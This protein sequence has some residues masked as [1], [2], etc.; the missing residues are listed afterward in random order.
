[1]NRIRMSL[2]KRH[3]C[4]KVKTVCM[5]NRFSL[6]LCLNT[7][8]LSNSMC[9][10]SGFMNH[11][12]QLISQSLRIEQS[13]SAVIRFVSIAGMGWNDVCLQDTEDRQLRRAWMS[14]SRQQLD[15]ISVS[16]IQLM[17]TVPFSQPLSAHI[18]PLGRPFLPVDQQEWTLGHQMSFLSVVS[19]AWY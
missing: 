8:N 19:Q 6:S 3:K 13:Y 15:K 11:D 12:Q 17:S 2:Y 7:F 4:L 16:D 14:G 9:K 1:M 18:S 5:L 10:T